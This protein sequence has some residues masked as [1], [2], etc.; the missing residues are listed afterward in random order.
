MNSLGTRAFM[1]LKLGS[2]KHDEKPDI[3]A[4]GRRRDGR[5]DIRV[6]VRWKLGRRRRVLDNGVG[7]TLD[8]S[9]GG[10]LFDAG[11]PLPAGLNV[12]LSVS[13]PVLL[14]NT[15]PLQLIVSGKI[16]RSN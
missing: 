2:D 6:E 10:L 12:E 9:S 1:N 5:Y 3:I 7:Q 4:G 13:W 14:H 15:A 11:R 16:V 8:L